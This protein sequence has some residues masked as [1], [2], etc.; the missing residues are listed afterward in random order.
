MLR[1]RFMA[2]IYA[3]LN[4]PCFFKFL[5]EIYFSGI[6]VM[7]LCDSGSLAT[8]HT[9]DRYFLIPVPDEWSLE[10]AATVPVVYSTVL[11]A[12]SVSQSILF[13]T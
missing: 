6:R 11:Y 5:S 3:Y 1:S 2:T 7:G 13:G 10:D 8:Q 12:F 9:A 4:T